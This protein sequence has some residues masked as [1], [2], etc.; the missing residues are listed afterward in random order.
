MSLGW[1]RQLQE[2]L[3]SGLHQLKG[4]RAQ[5]LPPSLPR[6]LWLSVGNWWCPAFSLSSLHS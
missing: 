4:T 6:A 3:S 5:G 2:P 1:R